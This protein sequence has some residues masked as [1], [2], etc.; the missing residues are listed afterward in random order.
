M[1]FDERPVKRVVAG[2]LSAVEGCLP[3][4]CGLARLISGEGLGYVDGG[5]GCP[6]Y[7]FP[8]SKIS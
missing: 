8:A 4:A 6:G 7:F 1:T 3:G 2:T 5:E